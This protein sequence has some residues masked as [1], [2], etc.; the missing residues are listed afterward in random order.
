M[1]NKDI[2][3]E[4]KL[5]PSEKRYSNF[6]VLII[7]N[8]LRIFASASCPPCPAAVSSFTVHLQSHPPA[9]ADLIGSPI[10]YMVE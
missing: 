9:F 8:M 4:K 6:K 3:L 1:T 5:S 2:A 7:R 10:Y